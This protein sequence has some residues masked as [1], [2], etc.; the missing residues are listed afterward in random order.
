M[1]EIA[2]IRA[3]NRFYTRQIGVLDASNLQTRFSLGEARIIYE[4][5][6]VIRVVR[7]QR[8]RHR[9]EVYR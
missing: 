9:R 3:F 8:I 5:A 7:V 6:D 1:D 4:I 2:E